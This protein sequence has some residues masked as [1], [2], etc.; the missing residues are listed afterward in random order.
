MSDVVDV[1]LV[2]IGPSVQVSHSAGVIANEGSAQTLARA[3]LGG[4]P[5]RLLDGEE[6]ERGAKQRGPIDSVGPPGLCGFGSDGQSRPVNIGSDIGA[7]AVVGHVGWCRRRMCQRRG[8][9]LR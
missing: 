5:K 3:Q 6:A 8:A 7:F 9:R 2:A 1:E 4:E